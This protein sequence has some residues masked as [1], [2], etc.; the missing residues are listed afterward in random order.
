[1]TEIEQLKA[2]IETLKRVGR[3]NGYASGYVVEP[4]LSQMQE[5]L[6]ELYALARDPHAIA[7][8][9]LDDWATSEVNAKVCA[10]CKHLEARVAEL[11]FELRCER[12]DGGKVRDD[13]RAR[14]YEL[15][16]K[17]KDK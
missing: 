8:K 16:R 2:D 7:R 6:V 3:I 1:M 9:I 4:L 10:Y 5:K 13:I 12:I 17:G 14:I 11:D 15:E